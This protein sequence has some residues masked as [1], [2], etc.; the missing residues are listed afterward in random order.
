MKHRVKIYRAGGIYHIYNRGIDG[1]DI[2]KEERD[3]EYWEKTME[4]YLLPVKTESPGR[5]KPDKPSV[6]S[7][8]KAM[9]LAGRVELLA[10]C[11]MPNHIHLLVRQTEKEGI[12][13]FMRRVMTNYVMYYNRRNQRR[14]QLFENVY[15][16]VMVENADSLGPLTKH[17][18]LNPVS[19]TIRRF[20]PVETVTGSRPEDYT[21]SSYRSYIGMDNK[22][23]VNTKLVKIIEEGD[24]GWE[25]KLEGLLLD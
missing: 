25:K 17:I 24:L 9:N 16:A 13:K 12:T 22:L 19:R 23:W 2:F 1:R 6:T 18:H 8:K 15:R 10:Y 11:L 3:Y 4:Q 14:G 5:F 7:K 20:G 21:H